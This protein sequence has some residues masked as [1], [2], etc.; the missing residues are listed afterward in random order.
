MPYAKAVGAKCQDIDDQGDET[1]TD[2]MRVMKIVTDAGYDGFV[3]IEYEGAK[4][5]EASGILA[6]KKLFELPS[7]ALIRRPIRRMEAGIE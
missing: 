6:C 3:G 5:D 7:G 2:Y 1:R 4:L